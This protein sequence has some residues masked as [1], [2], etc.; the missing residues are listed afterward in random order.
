MPKIKISPNWL[1]ALLIIV[2]IGISLFLRIYQPYSQIFVGDEIKYAS[3]DAYFYMRLVDNLSHHFPHLT[4]FDPYF[5]FPGG[6][7]VTSLPTFHWITAIIAWIAGAGNPS[8]HMIDII[9]VYLPAILGALVVVPVFFIGK[10]LFN[11]WAGVMAAGLIAVLPGEL[12]SRSMLGSGDNPVAEVFFTTTALAFLI[13]AI[14]KASQNQLSFTHLIKREWKVILKPIIY[15]L[16]GG[17][18]LGFYLTTWQG[19]LIFV[20]I[21]ILYTIVQYIVDHLRN[22]SS[23]YL[24]IIGIFSLLPALIILI[25][26]PMSTDVTIA[27]AIAF[28]VPPVLYVISRIIA[29]MGLKTYYYPITLVVIGVLAVV[30]A[31]FA[32]PGTFSMLL[33]KFKFVFLPSGSTAT[34][35]LEMTPMLLPTGDI[36]TPAVAWGNFTTS[37]FIAPWWLIFGIGAAAI[38]GYLIYLNDQSRSGKSLMVFLIIAAAIIVILTV[39]QVPKQYLM[40]DDQIKFIPGIAIIS[41][42]LLF[43]SFIKQRRERPLYFAILWVVAIL[44][45]LSMLVLFTT[46]SS[47]RY[48]APIPLAA[49]IYILFKQ[50]EGDEHLRFFLVWSLIILM[51]PMVQRRFQ[52]YLAINMALLSGYLVWQVIWQSGVKKLTQRAEEPKEDI[53]IS[54]TKMKKKAI[55]ERRSVRTHYL[56]AFLALVIVALYVFTPNISQ[57][58]AQSKNVSYALSDNWLAALNWMRDNTPDPMGDPD[59]YYT[60]YDALPPRESFNYPASAYGVTAWW[61]YGYWIIRIARRIPNTNPSQSSD[62]IRKVAAFFLSQDK[63]QID[64]LRKALGSKY[65]IVDYDIVPGKYWAMLNW[66]DLDQEK[67]I[68]TFYIQTTEEQVSA[69]QVFSVDYYRTLAVRLYNF[70]GQANPGGKAVVV[71]YQEVQDVSGMPFRLATDAKEFNSYQEAL[72]F[73]AEQDT[74]NKYM[75]VSADPFVSPIPLEAVEDYRLVYSSDNYPNSSIPEIKIFEYIG[76][77]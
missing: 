51:I 41:F 7:T 11:K 23:E 60:D 19:A 57:A 71:T 31:Y 77:D 28:F 34:T 1:V 27:M 36:Y 17:I 32:A 3:N 35:T 52:Y 53:N 20:A 8:Q 38:C 44:I 69:R 21:I 74:S 5:L 45:L 67:Y 15:S 55:A 24:C 76:D 6:N 68:P 10:T 50:S 59:A 65:V 39:L 22:K 4:Q 42:G 30:V 75:I 56:N 58:Q 54:K 61:D 43:Y 49:L 26:N 48:L 63:A 16:L 47:I 62:P 12:L 9:G 2:F 46:Y 73:I 25:L 18:F 66:A 72:D 64:E 14:K 37:F 13:M 33:A 70:N 40:T 29:R